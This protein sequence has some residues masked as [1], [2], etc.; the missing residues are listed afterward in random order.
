VAASE[1]EFELIRIIDAPIDHVFA[2]L[3][4]IDGYNEW[5]PAEGT[6]LKHTEQTS[7][8]EPSVGTTFVDDTTYG[9][10]PGE[11]VVYDPPTHVVYH[12][13]DKR[14]NGE[15]KTEGWPEFTLESIDDD[16]TRVRH[17]ARLR[18]HGLSRLGMPL[19]RRLAVKER[20]VTIDALKASFERP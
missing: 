3:T 10:T 2:R 12:W 18:A 13:W 20:T 4:D 5:M 19:W 6:M 14:P 17:H 1:F 16:T 11:I 9:L 8:G 7:P 15:V